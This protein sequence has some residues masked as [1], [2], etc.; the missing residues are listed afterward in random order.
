MVLIANTRLPPPPHKVERQLRNWGEGVEL[1]IQP[2]DG[3]T[4]TCCS[5]LHRKPAKP[6]HEHEE[7]WVRAC[8]CFS[9]GGDRREWES[10]E[11]RI[12]FD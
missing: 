5:L 4:R 8:M 7:A 1:I 3:A 10:R 2:V 12:W 11:T 6:Q 9:G